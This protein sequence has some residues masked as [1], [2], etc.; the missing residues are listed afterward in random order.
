MPDV[1]KYIPLYIYTPICMYRNTHIHTREYLE[2]RVV[3]VTIL[4]DFSCFI[5]LFIQTRQL[6]RF[7]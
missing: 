5:A 1:Y 3:Y 4:A 6:L 7:F 2:K